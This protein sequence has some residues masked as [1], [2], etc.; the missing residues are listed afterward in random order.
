MVPL[1]RRRKRSL[2]LAAAMPLIGPALACGPAGAVAAAT[3]HSL[4]ALSTNPY[5]PSIESTEASLLHPLAAPLMM[6]ASGR[7]NGVGQFDGVFTLT[8]SGVS[9]QTSPAISYSSA[10][11]NPL[12]GVTNLAW[13][14][15]SPTYVDTYGQL[16]S[17][18]TLTASGTWSDSVGDSGTFPPV[19][20]SIPDCTNPASSN[21]PPAAAY[22]G[23]NF[24]A[25]A[26]L[27]DGQGYW[28]VTA[29]G[30]VSDFGGAQPY[31]DPFN[32]GLS[33]PIVGMASTLDGQG[34]WLVAADGGIFAYGD[35]VFYGSTGNVHLNQPIVGMTVTPDG[36][37]YWFVASDGGVFAF[38]DAVFWGSMGGSPL[39]DPVVGMAADSATGGYWLVAGDGGV[40]SFNA[41]F[42]GSTG[43]IRLNQPVV[44]MEAAANGS[45]YRFVASD[46][47]IFCYNV[48]FE[49]SMGGQPLNQPVVGMA[50]SG[51]DGYW[52]IA[53]D[54][55]LFT[56][57]TAG[58]FGSPLTS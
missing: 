22:A 32:T 52:L 33:Q 1:S 34:Y 10:I 48:P 50:T 26:A 11:N 15:G 7:C 58:F 5:G 24:V 35:A 40:F 41:P 46:G 14:S 8:I 23:G 54:G 36:K 13:D 44:G 53:G 2:I 56:F 45:G 25:M 20:A 12:G 21:T 37:G 28:E 55:G 51:T 49:G 31:G 4:N 19:T 57:G 30:Q 18:A 47:G 3:A 9:T 39:N 43:S 17:P 42:Y 38:G 16:S 27:P 29:N 6:T